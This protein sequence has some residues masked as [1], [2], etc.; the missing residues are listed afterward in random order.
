MV[1]NSK[2]WVKYRQGISIKMFKNKYEYGT[3]IKILSPDIGGVCY[4]TQC[5]GIANLPVP[6]LDHFTQTKINSRD[7]ATLPWGYHV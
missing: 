6:Y 5:M 3:G 4:R 1:F 7:H 2:G